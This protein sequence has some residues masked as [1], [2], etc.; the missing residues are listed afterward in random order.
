MVLLIVLICI[1]AELT[2]IDLSAI[3]V[4]FVISA[5]IGGTACMA[6]E[7]PYADLNDAPVTRKHW[8]R[9]YLER[10]KK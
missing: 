9:E 7:R 10:R 6:M 2:V 8:A 3:A 4:I 1:I 5:V